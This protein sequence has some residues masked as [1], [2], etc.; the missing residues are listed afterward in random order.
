MSHEEILK[1]VER[2]AVILKAPKGTVLH[3]FLGLMEKI[4][5]DHVKQEQFDKDFAL[6]DATSKLQ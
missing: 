2:I 6:S 4:L 5:N 1:E 3:E